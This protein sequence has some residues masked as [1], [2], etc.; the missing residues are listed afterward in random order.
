MNN[1]A[2]LL[3][4]NVD[5]NRIQLGSYTIQKESVY[6][7]ASIILKIIIILVSMYLAIKIGNKI[8]ER[9]ISKQKHFRFSLDEKKAKTIGAIL[10]SVL[11]YSVYFIGVLSIIETRFGRIGLTFA[12]IGGVAIGFGSQSLV[13]D[14]INGFFILFEDQFAVG[15]YIHIDDKGGVV[16]SMELR[17]T[18]IRDFNGDLHIVPNGLIT[19]VTN[20][21][22]G[23]IKITIDADIAYDEDV[24]K[25]IEVISKLCKRFKDEND[26]VTEGPEVL[27]VHAFK[28]GGVT[29]RVSGR[30]KPM[31][32]W[33]T[34]M[35]LR[36]E[37]RE[38]LRSENINI[39]YP[40]VRLVKE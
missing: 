16:E 36:K 40:K 25:A 9:Y 18:K 12:G 17:V 20:H 1:L 4:F 8:I 27:G 28:E 32:Q 15:D 5:S 7:S 26:N 13:K 23:N 6:N 29:I 35:K 10:K 19:K 11:K 24:D 34:E 38:V 14:I 33:D 39:P 37:I 21:S 31:S 2:S 30:T 3:N 22:R